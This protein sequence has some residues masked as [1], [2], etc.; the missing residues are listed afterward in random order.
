MK[1]YKFLNTISGWIVFFIASTVYVLTSE[2]TASFWDC[3]EYISTA[4]KLQVG[5]PPG[6]PLFQLLGRFFSMFAF[7]DVALVARMINTMSAL[8]SGFTILFLFWTITALTKKI[9]FKSEKISLQ[10]IITVLG[11]GFVGAMAFT[12]SDSFWFSAVEGEVYATSSFFTAI[13]FWAILKWEEVADEPYANR[14]L[15]FIAFLTGLSIGVH[16]LNLL[17][18][19]AMTMVYYYRK[20]NH[21]KKNITIALLL[22]LLILGFVQSGII[23]WTVKLAGYFELFF[24]NTA[25]MPF[26]AG[27]IIYFALLILLIV[28]G[29]LISKKRGKTILNTIVLSLAF[30][31]LGYSSFLVLVIRSNANT[32]IN[33]N[34]P[35]DAISLLR[36]LN[37]EQYGDWPLLYGPYFNAPYDSEEPYVDGK[38]VY[39]RD[40]AQKKY[41]VVDDSK[42]SE[43]NYD[44]RFYTFFPRMWSRS[45]DLHARGYQTWSKMDGKPITVTYRNGSEE[46]INKPTFFENLRFFFTYQVGHM[47][48]RYFMWNF[49]GR[50]ND[51]QGYGGLLNGNWMTGIKAIDKIRL[52]PQDNLPETYANAK[53]RNYFYLL[54]LL[55]GLAGFF[56]QLN[57][58]FKGFLVVI[59]LFIF[60]GLAINVY[61]NPVPYQP[62]ERD[63]AYA[64]SFY[65]FAIWIGLGVIGINQALQKLKKFIKPVILSLA[66]V[67]LSILFVPVLMAR[68]GWDDHD[69]SNRYT[70]RDIASD[71]L[72]SCAPNAILFTLGDNDTFPLWYAQEVEGIRTDIRVV[73]LNLLNM[74]WY[75]DQM[76]HKVYDSEPLPITLDNKKYIASKRDYVFV[77]EDTN[78]V[79]PNTYANLKALLDFAT[80]DDDALKIETTRGTLNY[81]PTRKFS[82]PVDTS[83][84]LNNGTVPSE[85]ADSV[86]TDIRW[87]YDGHLV[88]KNGLAVFNLLSELK[89]KRPVYF[90][91]TTGDD[92]YLNLLDYLQLEGLAYRL[93]PYR[94]HPIDNETGRVNTSIM[95][96]NMMNRFAYGNMNSDGIYLDETNMRLTNTFRKLFSRLAT[97]LMYEEKQDKALKVCDKCIEV[98]PDNTVPYNHLLLPII[99]TYYQCGQAEKANPIVN[100]LGQYCE[101][102]LVYFNQFKGTHA[103]YISMEKNESL[104]LLKKL[105]D[106]AETYKQSALKKQLNT[107]FEKYN[108]T[109]N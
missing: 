44:K 47:Y 68:E 14:W 30:L 17:C 93:V 83:I 63:Y 49:S 64:A 99:T 106:I 45:S 39:A 75:I 95:Y 57:K 66:A 52:G 41:V 48:L 107:V 18:I 90:A 70:A 100:R 78:L 23:P 7:G 26:N 94:C 87:Q 92:A 25:G 28:L 8:A 1:Q 73:N 42:L 15:V 98:M 50:Q 32:P 62:R 103:V 19:P 10:E 109:K 56:I 5:H 104:D 102:E 51:Q 91:S 85:Y 29:L 96:E 58:D 61:L 88:M 31:L 89:W 33:E 43:N 36:Y 108:T 12:F 59:L 3:G 46:L 67:I 105:I 80:S 74:D 24:V 13:V 21:S 37:R 86:V 40:D 60:T 6:A 20:I 79:K 69:R 81:F 35:K 4:Y 22:S 53:G 55:L 54:P 34:A 9:V 16:L 11:A 71:Y 77:Y 82:L 72:N 38:P 97:A 2:P 84:V 27:I 65:A 76:K 101:Q